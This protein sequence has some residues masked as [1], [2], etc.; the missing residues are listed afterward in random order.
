MQNFA[1]Y[2][3]ELRQK[4]KASTEV[5][6]TEKDLQ[7]G[8]QIIIKTPAEK[9][10]LSVYNGKKGRKLVWGGS[11]TPLR[12][13]LQ[14]LVEGLPARTLDSKLAAP[15]T[16]P[17][18]SLLED[19]A[20]FNGIWT[21]SDESGKG[22]FFGPLVV[23]AV[24]TNLEVGQ[25]LLEAGVKDCK[26]VQDKEILKLAP[27]I[28]TLAPNHVVLA[29]KPE[30]YNFRYA[31]LKKEGKNLN[32]LLAY[33]HIAAL[34]QTL[35]KCPECSYALVD[36]FTAKNNIAAALNH[37]FSQLNVVQQHRAES[38]IAVAAASILAR[39]EFLTIMHELSLVAGYDLPRGG[40]KLSTQCAQQILD[41]HGSQFLHKLVK[42]HF[43]NYRELK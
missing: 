40:G 35:E 39:A 34:K 16:I 9:I 36:Q 14:A 10:V 7:Y 12:N 37:D 28:K 27:I 13:T 23:A 1:D 8:R 29:M 25:L 5:T 21:G 42:T 41:E 24:Q 38:D 17:P 20:G 6:L 31:Q 11:A 18:L 22:D 33:G 15:K 3:E 32:H 4:L 26:V 30:I 43:A 19:C 2:L